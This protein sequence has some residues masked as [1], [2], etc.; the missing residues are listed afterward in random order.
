MTKGAAREYQ[1]LCRD[2]LQRRFG[3]RPLSGDGVDVPFEAAGTTF[4][5][6][7]ALT[8]PYNAAEGLVLA[9]CRNTASA[10][11]QDDVAAFAFK[12]EKIRAATG[13]P[14]A[15]F[16]MTKTEPQSGAIK[17]EADVV[18][19]SVVVVCGTEL[20]DA[21]VAFLR[22]DREREAKLRGHVMLAQRGVYE[23]RGGSVRMIVG[24]A[25]GTTEE[26]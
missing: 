12:V 17:L 2:V 11:K 18:A 14:V 9:E 19:L 23:L 6:D 22:Y 24:R 4:A 8:S 1:L 5:V 10:Q 21:R 16:F 7:V 13:E 25:D 20:A 15:A 3:G 26:G